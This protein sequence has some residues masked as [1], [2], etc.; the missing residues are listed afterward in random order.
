MKAKEG[1][2]PTSLSR[3]HHVFETEEGIKEYMS[4]NDEEAAAHAFWL[5]DE[6]EY[7]NRCIQYFEYWLNSLSLHATR[8]HIPLL[9]IFH[10]TPG[11][12]EHLVHPGTEPICP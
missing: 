3:A 6:I 5:Q 11:Y 4:F 2:S 9:I 8:Y 1:L 12:S 10:F 7:A